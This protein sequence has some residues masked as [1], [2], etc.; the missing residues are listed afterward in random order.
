MLTIKNKI[1]Y[2]I[3]LYNHRNEQ[4]RLAYTRQYRL[5]LGKESYFGGE[6]CL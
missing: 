6:H 2:K 4:E 5:K 3:E 1:Q